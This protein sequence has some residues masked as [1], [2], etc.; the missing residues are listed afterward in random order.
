MI[1]IRS[2]DT[3]RHAAELLAKGGFDSLPVV[4][5]SSALGGIVTITDL[6]RCL[7]EPY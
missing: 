1:S 7:L 4:E 3:I 6:I 5:G 2:H